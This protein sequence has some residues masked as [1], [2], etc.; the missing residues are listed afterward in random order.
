MKIICY[1]KYCNASMV[2]LVDALDSKSND[3]KVVSVR[4]RL[5][6]PKKIKDNLIVFFILNIA[7]SLRIKNL[8]NRYE[9]DHSTFGNDHPLYTSLQEINEL[10]YYTMANKT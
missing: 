5:L 8:I 2:E 6:V 3:R 7:S 9:S 1:N 10:L 4:L